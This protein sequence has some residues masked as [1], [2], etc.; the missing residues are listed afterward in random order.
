MYEHDWAISASQHNRVL[1]YDC[2]VLLDKIWIR[3]VR[4]L[5]F[6][7]CWLDVPRVLIS[8][9]FSVQVVDIPQCR[10][11]RRRHGIHLAVIGRLKVCV[12]IHH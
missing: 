12:G 8:M 3:A 6:V 9:M 5:Q 2:I 10:G 11:P 1:E 4:C 7:S